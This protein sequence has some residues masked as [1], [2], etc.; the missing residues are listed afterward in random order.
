MAQ[1]WGS[2]ERCA[3][4]P[5]PSIVEKNV[6][7][8]GAPGCSATFA[9]KANRTASLELWQP[10]CLKEKD[11]QKEKAPRRQYVSGRKSFEP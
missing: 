11:G 7:D 9:N 10:A 3:A 1:A 6:A 5:E 8:C 2:E 4:T